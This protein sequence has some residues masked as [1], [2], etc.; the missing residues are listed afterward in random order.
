M[1]R[2]GVCLASVSSVLVL[3]GPTSAAAHEVGLA[4]QAGNGHFSIQLT[5][6]EVPGGG[7][8]DGRGSATLD[9]D[10]NKTQAC[11]T[12]TWSQLRGQVTA[13]HLHVAARGGEGPQ[14]IDFFDH[15]S[16][17]GARSTASGCVPSSHDNINAVIRHPADYYLNVD[18]TTLGKGAIRGRLS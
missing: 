11:F 13:L 17:P 18:S 15:Q 10:P 7:D 6:G 1:G 16:F 14:W 12:I 3:V 8:P 4:Y 5:G 2:V 9:L